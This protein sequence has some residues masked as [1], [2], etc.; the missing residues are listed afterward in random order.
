MAGSGLGF[1]DC[2]QCWEYA[3]REPERLGDVCGERSGGGYGSAGASGNRRG[4]WGE[5]SNRADGARGAYR[6]GGC[7]GESWAGLSG[8][9]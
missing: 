1:F 4:E 9:V 6:C 5:W 3:E 2:E 8:G 7:G